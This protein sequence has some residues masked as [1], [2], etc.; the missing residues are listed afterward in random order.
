[1]GALSHLESLRPL[2]NLVAY[3]KPFYFYAYCNE[4]AVVLGE[5]GRIAEAEAAVTVALSSP[6]A[7]AYPNW[8]ETRQEIEAKCTSATPS[9]VAVTQAPQA[10][11][12][13]PEESETLKPVKSIAFGW[14]IS[15][16]FY[17][18]TAIATLGLLKLGIHRQ[19][20]CTTLE[21]LGS[22]IQS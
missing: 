10:N 6:F 15:T 8:A 20:T 13:L 16:R 7:S 19:T 1:K 2:V 17:F 18:Q 22:C 11:P 4:S 14:L 21:Q 5:L 3:Q 12:S 9:V